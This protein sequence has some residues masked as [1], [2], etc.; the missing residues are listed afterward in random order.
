M[1]TNGLQGQ[2]RV[3]DEV[4]DQGICVGCGAC[5]GL[6]PYFQYFDGKV[7]VVDRCLAENGRCLQVCPMAGYEGTSPKTKGP[8]DADAS[9]ASENREIGSFRKIFTARATDEKIREN[10]QYGGVVSA[11]VIYALEKGYIHSAVLT[12]SGKHASPEGSIAGNRSDVIKCSGSRYSASGGLAALNLAIKEG[13]DRVGVVGLPCQMEAVARMQQV[14]HMQQMR[15]DGKKISGR[16]ELKIGLF[17]TWAVDY[18][19][20]DAF[21]KYKGIKESVK[22]FDI[23][24]PPAEKFQVKTEKGWTDFPLSE[25]RPFIQK[26][27][28]LCQDMT[29]EM[30]DISV[31]TVEGRKGWNTVIVRTIAGEKIFNEAVASGWIQTGNLPEDSFN[32][33]KQASNNKRTRGMKAKADMDRSRA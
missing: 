8:D 31:G 7:V 14:H 3:I 33:L 4:I 32:H 29:A 2:F 21:L 25:I 23:P 24:P 11:I 18:R 5:V 27:C 20:L 28:G 1:K 17:C 26:G 22:K 16:I 12:N 13:K 15:Q 19:A 30:A 6:C 10:A 9:G